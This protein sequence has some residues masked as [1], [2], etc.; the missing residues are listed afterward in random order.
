MSSLRIEIQGQVVVA[1]LA[2]APV[3]VGRDPSCDLRIDDPTVSAAHASI[4]PHR[5]GGYRLM[6]LRSGLPTKVN[7]AVVQRV[8]EPRTGLLLLILHH[9]AFNGRGERAR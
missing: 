8:G 6:D 1:R 3:R 2:D 7:G 5:A 9:R 4:D